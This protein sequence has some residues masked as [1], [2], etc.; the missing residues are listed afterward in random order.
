ETGDVVVFLP[1]SPNPWSGSV[2]YFREDRIRTL[3]LTVPEA[4]KKIRLLGRGS[5]QYCEQPRKGESL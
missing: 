5:V 2:A 1:G 4:I 3:N